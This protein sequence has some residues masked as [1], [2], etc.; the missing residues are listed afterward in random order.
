MKHSLPILSLV[1]AVALTGL[2]GCSSFSSSSV[3]DASQTASEPSAKSSSRHAG[4]AA[5]GNRVQ[6]QDDAGTVVV[7]KVEFKSGISS[8][9]VERLAREHGCVG[10]GGAG[11]MTEKGPVEVYRMQCENGKAFLARCEL[12][13]CRPMR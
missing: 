9:T 12:R 11:L 3:K 6:V 10:S 13:Q 1:A 2:T 7:E 5:N 8:A 4:Q